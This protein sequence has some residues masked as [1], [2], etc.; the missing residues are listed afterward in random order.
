MTI[1]KM[2][3]NIYKMMSESQQLQLILKHNIDQK[4]HTDKV[5]LFSSSPHKIHPGSCLYFV[6]VIQPTGCMESTKSAYPLILTVFQPCA[7]CTP[8]LCASLV[9]HC[10][11]LLH[12]GVQVVQECPAQVLEVPGT[13]ISWATIPEVFV[14]PCIDTVS[15]QACLLRWCPPRTDIHSASNIRKPTGCIHEPS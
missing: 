11:Q 6:S 10:V 7:L 12:G 8:T 13:S 15:V 9:P 5:E 4:T 2:T 3:E 14:K 1:Q